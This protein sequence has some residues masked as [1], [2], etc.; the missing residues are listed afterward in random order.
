MGCILVSVDDFL[1][2]QIYGYALC[3]RVIHWCCSLLC[4]WYSYLLN[5]VALVEF[6][7]VIRNQTV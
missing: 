3:Y 5:R 4:G 2:Y 6:L 1:G 7:F